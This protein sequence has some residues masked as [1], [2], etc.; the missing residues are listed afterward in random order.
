MDTSDATDEKFL[1][2]HPDF[3]ELHFV[4]CQPSGKN[5]NSDDGDTESL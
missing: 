4:Q 2:F 5:V 1:P 3:L